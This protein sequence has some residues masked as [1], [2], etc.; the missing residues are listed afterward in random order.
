[1]LSLKKLKTLLQK[2]I[3]MSKN[4]KRPIENQYKVETDEQ[5]DQPILLTS[6][7]RYLRSNDAGRDICTKKRVTLIF[8]QELYVK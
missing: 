6:R 8:I 7:E 3:H 1:M 2:D 5:W 4:K